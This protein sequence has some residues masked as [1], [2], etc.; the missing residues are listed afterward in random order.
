VRRLSSR[1]CITAPKLLTLVLP[2]ILWPGILTAQSTSMLQ[3]GCAEY[4]EER[5]LFLLHCCGDVQKVVYPGPRFTGDM[6]DHRRAELALDEIKAAMRAC[7]EDRRDRAYLSLQLDAAGANLMKA[8]SVAV[9]TNPAWNEAASS[10]EVATAA[11]KRFY[12]EHPLEAASVWKVIEHWLHEGGGPWQAL[13]FIN[14]LPSESCSAAELAKVRGDLFTEIDLSALAA[15]SYSEWIK[16][17][18]TPQN[19]GNELSLFNVDMLRK[20]GF[21]LPALNVTEEILCTNTGY[22]YYVIL[23]HKPRGASHDRAPVTPTRH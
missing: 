1:L 3:P 8:R 11:L 20:A 7:N 5:V 9:E 17:G 2:I 12:E 10:A 21:D 15:Q 18:G 14:R 6:T 16:I 13:A 19:C 22:A 23:P 4:H